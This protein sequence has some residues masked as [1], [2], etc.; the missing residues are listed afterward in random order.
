M[1]RALPIL[2][3]LLAAT[4]GIAAHAERASDLINFAFASRLGSGIYTTSGG[5]LWILRVPASA[6]VIRPKETR[7]YRASLLLPVTVGIL[8]FEPQD[9]LESGLPDRFDSL[10]FTPGLRFDVPAG[11]VWTLSPFAQ[12]GPVRDFSTDS[13]AWVYSIGATAEARIPKEAVEWVVRGELAWSGMN[14]HGEALEETF[15]EWI[16]GFE[17]WSPL[18]ARMGDA[19]LVLGGFAATTLYWRRARFVGDS[20]FQPRLYSLQGEVGLVLS[21]RPRTHVWKVRVPDLGLSTR[22]GDGFDSIR[23]VF[24]KTF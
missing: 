24:G 12:G 13:T 7:T 17:V 9:I 8:D 10:G 18:P 2:L 3:L 5:T 6:T 11:A 15:G 21:T 23:L 22:F 4:S 19:R 20:D 1:S 14:P 16:S